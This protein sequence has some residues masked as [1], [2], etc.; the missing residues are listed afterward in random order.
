MF[1]MTLLS[2]CVFVIADGKKDVTSTTTTVTGTNVST[3]KISISIVVDELAVPAIDQQLLDL[4][5]ARDAGA[6]SEEEYEAE[7]AKWLSQK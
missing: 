7:K 2:G 3:N 5:K 4:K 6:I 1:A